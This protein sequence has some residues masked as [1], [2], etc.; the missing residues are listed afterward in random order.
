MR[1][2]ISALFVERLRGK[3]QSFPGVPK[4]PNASQGGESTQ[5]ANTNLLQDRP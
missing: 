4:T 1:L 2:E 5:F 3:L